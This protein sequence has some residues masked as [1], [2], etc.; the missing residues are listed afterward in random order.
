[1]DDK[2]I[3]RCPKC[4]FRIFNRRYPRCESCKTLLPSELVYSAEEVKELQSSEVDIE[5]EQVRHKKD[6]STFDYATYYFA[7]Y[8]LNSNLNSGC[9]ISEKFDSSGGNDCSGSGE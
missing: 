6:D 9:D 2:D 1:M 4:G 7:Q 3:Y 5:K 8:V